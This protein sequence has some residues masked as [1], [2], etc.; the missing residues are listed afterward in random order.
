ML[1]EKQKEKKKAYIFAGGGTAGHVNPALRI[2]DELKGND[3]EAE[4]LF[5][6]TEEGLEYE[7]VSK[8]G[9][10][11]EVIRASAYP[12]KLRD[13]PGFIYNTL[14][15][16][17]RA[18]RIMK[19]HQTKLVL[20][21]GG[22]VS[23][24]AILAAKLAGIPAFLHEQNALPGRT[25]RLLSKFSRQIFLSFPSA[26]KY[27]PNPH[28]K[29]FAYLGNP[30]HPDFFTNQK[31]TVRKTLS[32]NED[33]FL[34]VCLGGSLGAK[35]INE[36]VV[37]M[38]KSKAWQDFI[39]K[40]SQV[41]LLLSAG[42]VNKI[43]IREEQVENEQV[44]VEEFI[45]TSLWMPASDLLVGRA[46]AGFLAEAAAC[47]KASILIPFP[48][49]ADNHQEINAQ[50]YADHGAAVKVNDRELTGD[51]LFSCIYEL[52]LDET[53]RRDMEE[54]MLS[55]AKEKAA[56]DIAEILKKTG[57]EE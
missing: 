23:A 57:D 39:T 40:Y 3:P 16:I 51:R 46:G 2:A 28:K 45:D 55:L 52:F 44:R 50:I 27:F 29:E 9:H 26:E 7:L 17:F 54:A 35:T 18:F 48:E 37:Q 25:N 34:I 53:K 5:L 21:T 12:Q 15:S 42:K 31:E 36:A 14:F 19:Q 30:V 20:G 24:A 10:S 33:D 8:S 4:M 32:L 22:Y 11:Y 13:W 47:G 56:R 6:V 38:V 41:K 1:K 43:F 49:A